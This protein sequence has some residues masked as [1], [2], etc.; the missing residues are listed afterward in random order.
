ME[1]KRQLNNVC[2]LAIFPPDTA[3]V[4]S[5][6]YFHS[7][8]GII[9]SINVPANSH[10]SSGY[11]RIDSILGFAKMGHPMAL[12]V[13]DGFPIQNDWLI[14]F[15]GLE[16]VPHTW[17]ETSA[18][19]PDVLLVVQRTWL[20]CYRP[21]CGHAAGCKFGKTPCPEIREWYF[22]G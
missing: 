3:S 11:N 1:S 21:R 17:L 10:C 13:S 15:R 8:V 4:G 12:L 5:V 6:W 20:L 19:L 14:N 2:W 9:S 22:M 18:S 16:W 7:R